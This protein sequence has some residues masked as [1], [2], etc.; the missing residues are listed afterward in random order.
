MAARRWGILTT[1][2]ASS[3]TLHVDGVTVKFLGGLTAVDN[4]SLDLK[5][6]QITALIGPQRLGKSTL[7]NA[8]SG[9]YRPVSG[10]IVFQREPISPA[11]M[12]TRWRA[13]AWSAHLPGSAPGAAPHGARNLLLGAHPPAGIPAWQLVRPGLGHRGG[14]RSS[15]GAD[16][17]LKLTDLHA[18]ADRTIDTLPYGYCRLAEVGRALIAQPRAILLDEPAAGL[19]ET[20][21]ERLAKVIRD[22]KAMGLII[23]LIEHHMDFVAE[24][25]D[26]VVGT[27]SGR[28]IYRGDVAG[29]PAIPRSS[30]PTW[31]ARSCPCLT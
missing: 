1:H 28:V 6:G 3:G 20:E 30:P 8:I 22:M 17:V 25:V 4:V 23:L 19:S 11:G 2:A 5:P 12:I 21:M 18:V 31:A 24:L 27:D 7:V 15:A 9:I 14:S 29:M 16:S 26:D 13:A 10:R